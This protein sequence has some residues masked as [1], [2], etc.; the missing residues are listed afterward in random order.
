MRYVEHQAYQPVQQKRRE[1]EE[2]TLEEMIA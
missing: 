2:E 1:K